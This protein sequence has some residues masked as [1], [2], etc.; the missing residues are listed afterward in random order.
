MNTVLIHVNEDGH[1]DYAYPS[2]MKL[3]VGPN[4][5]GVETNI[6]DKKLAEWERTKD[7]HSKM[8]DEL[9]KLYYGDDL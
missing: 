7:K 5:V 1:L 3:A 6:S 2:A 8:Q 9:F 4:G